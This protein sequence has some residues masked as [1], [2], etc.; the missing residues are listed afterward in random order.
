MSA[1]AYTEQAPMVTEQHPNHLYG[2]QRLASKPVSTWY[3]FHDVAFTPALNIAPH[4][5]LI[6]LF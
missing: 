1:G 2:S 3:G 5:Q 6:G 4:V